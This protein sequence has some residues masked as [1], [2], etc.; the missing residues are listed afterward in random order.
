MNDTAAPLVPSA[1]RLL[2]AVTVTFC[3]TLNAAGVNVR[4]AG[5]AVAALAVSLDATAIMTLAVGWEPRETE[6]TPGVAP[7]VTVRVAGVRKTAICGG[8]AAVA[9]QVCT[10][11][12]DR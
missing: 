11:R 9:L 8:R 12:K 7:S 10:G 2:T 5:D 6:M 1:M 3:T 4:L